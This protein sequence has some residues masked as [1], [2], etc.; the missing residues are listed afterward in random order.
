MSTTYNY[1]N[2][3]GPERKRYLKKLGDLGIEDCPYELPA[4]VWNNDPT[5]WPCLEYPEVYEY[6]INNNT[7]GVFTREAMKNRKSLEAHNQFQSGWVRTVHH[8]MP[9][10]P[11]RTIRLPN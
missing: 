10:D 3:E 11:N 7:P 2:L 6:L 8:Y 1:R 9:G 4:D 5:C